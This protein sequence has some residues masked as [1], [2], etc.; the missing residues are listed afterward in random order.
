MARGGV[1]WEC[2]AGL[3]TKGCLNCGRYLFLFRD[4]KEALSVVYCA[5]STG[6]GR[7]HVGEGSREDR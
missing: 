3:A 1:V 7:A 4:L 6:Q 2:R 5:G